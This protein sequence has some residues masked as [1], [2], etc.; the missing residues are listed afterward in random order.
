LIWR[1]RADVVAACLPEEEDDTQET[2]R[3]VAQV[4][5]TLEPRAERAGVAAAA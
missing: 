4:G 1:K 3:W 2:A 5:R